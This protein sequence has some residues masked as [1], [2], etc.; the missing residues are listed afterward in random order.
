MV[1]YPKG[2]KITDMPAKNEIAIAVRSIEAAVNELARLRTYFNE[3]DA[4][5][6]SESGRL[7]TA[8]VLRR[9]VSVLTDILWLLKDLIT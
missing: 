9:Q 7:A 6:L 4:A 3:G 8:D 1:Y 5:P 2:I